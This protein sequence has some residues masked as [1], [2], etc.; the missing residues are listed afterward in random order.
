M[1]QLVRDRAG[2][3]TQLFQV[4]V[5]GSFYFTIP[6]NSDALYNQMDNEYMYKII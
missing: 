2:T 6:F 5:Q 3:M 1:A 4:L